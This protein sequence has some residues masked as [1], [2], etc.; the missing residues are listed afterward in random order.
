MGGP[1]ND[2]GLEA[3]RKATLVDETDP[4]CY[5]LSF[6]QNLNNS[7][8]L[9]LTASGTFNMAGDANT[10]WIDTDGLTRGKFQ[11]VWDGDY[12]GIISTAIMEDTN[13]TSILPDE[14]GGDEGGVVL[15]QIGAGSQGFQFKEFTGRYI[16]LAFTSNDATAGIATW[17]FWGTQ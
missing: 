2:S 9:G 1:V 15:D 6:R 5:H 10:P 12:D 16:R 17:Y 11:L 13:D 7:V 3:I 4:T 8:K 14:L